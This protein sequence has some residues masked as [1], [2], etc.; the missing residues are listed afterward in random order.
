MTLVYFGNYGGIIL[1]V[2]VKYANVLKKAFHHF[3]TS[4]TKGDICKSPVNQVLALPH[5][6][7]ITS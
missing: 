6:F 5:G 3:T 4:E 7:R 2:L 1:L